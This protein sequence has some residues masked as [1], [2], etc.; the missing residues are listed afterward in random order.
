MKC[1]SFI[2]QPSRIGQERERERWLSHEVPE[3]E[4]DGKE[5]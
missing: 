3:K 4:V 2:E 1:V 5:N